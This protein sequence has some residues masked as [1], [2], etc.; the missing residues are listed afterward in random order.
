M[1]SNSLST[2]PRRERDDRLRILLIEDSEHDWLSFRR[3]FQKSQVASEITCCVRAEEALQRLDTDSSSFDLVVTD[4][5]L[6]GMNGL[7]LCRELLER[8]VP[9]PLV[10]LTGT[11]TE[12]LAVEALKAGVDDYLIKDPSQGYLALLPVVLPDVVRKHND[13]LARRRAEAALRESEERLRL[14][15]Q[16]MPVIIDAVDAQGNMVLWNR[17]CERVTGY[18]ADEIIGNPRAMELLYLDSERL[19]RVTAEVAEHTADFRDLEWDI[20]CKDGSV[21]TVSWANISNQV[22]IPGW[23][24][25]AVGVDITERKR[26]EEA[27][28]ELNATLEAQVAKRTAEIRAEKEKSETILHSVGDAIVMVDLEMRIQYVNDAFI[29]LTGYTAEEVM[30]QPHMDLLA[31][32][33][34]AEQSRQS[35]RLAL[36]KGEVWQGEVTARRKDGRTYEAALTIAPM[37]DAAGRLVGYVSSHRDISRFKDLDRARSRFITNISHELRT[38]VANMKLYVHLLRK[39][40][41][42]EKTERYMEVVSE[43]VERLEHLIQDILEMTGLDSGQAIN[44]WE[45]VSLPTVISDAVTRYQSQA[46]AADLALIAMP[47]PPDLPAV[48]GD[49]SRLAQSLGELVENAVIFTPTGGRVIIEAEAVEEGGQRWVTVAVR[50]TGPGISP[51]EQE[52]VFV[53]FYRGSLA[54]SGHV[55]GTG[56]GLSF[57]EEIMRAHGG[58][59]T[60]DSEEGQGST[61]TL[62]LRSVPISVEESV[63]AR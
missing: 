34:M 20:K 17:E 51:Q 10:L 62:W 47:V 39:G 59:V 25:W 14:L 3:A 8:E 35:L 42:A 43:Q 40:M 60:V 37:R 7:E 58:R 53:R 56:L 22:P 49:Q 57:V 23:A 63:A 41:S 31:G 55:P 15:V 1:D 4:H 18:G 27:L 13:R 33:V 24:Q 26:A 44:A 54:E 9:L 21:K 12:Y 29:A 16:N 46:E 32:E 19:E 50:D 6:P 2:P 45:P 61:F 5:K 30:G 38:P 52:R 11:G 48:K 36:D 28:R